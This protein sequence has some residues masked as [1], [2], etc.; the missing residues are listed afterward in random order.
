MRGKC[1]KQNPEMP[2]KN[3]KSTKRKTRI[4]WWEE[5]VMTWQWYWEFRTG[6][7]AVMRNAKTQK[8]REICYSYFCVI[9]HSFSFIYFNSFN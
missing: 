5:T 4:D 3:E 1:G 2:K 8:V 9:F 7:S 6:K